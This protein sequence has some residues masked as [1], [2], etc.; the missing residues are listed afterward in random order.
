M[1]VCCERGSYGSEDGARDSVGLARSEYGI[2]DDGASAIADALKTNA[3]LVRLYLNNNCIGDDGANALADA[4]RVNTNHKLVT[5]N[6][7]GNE[8]VC[9]QAT[10]AVRAQLKASRLD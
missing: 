4:L 9:G 3:T 5:L 10:A 1:P 7:S 6:L 8:Q 2:G